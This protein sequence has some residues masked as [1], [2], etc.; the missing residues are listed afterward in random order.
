MRRGR[1][2]LTDFGIARR[3]ASGGWSKLTSIIAAWH[4]VF[5][6]PEVSRTN[7]ADPTADQYASRSSSLRAFMATIG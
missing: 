2:R 4:F 3:P 5:S 1:A 6:A 7:D